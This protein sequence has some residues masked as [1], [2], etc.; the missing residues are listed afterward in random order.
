MLCQFNGY[1]R[2]LAKWN[3]YFYIGQSK[4]RRLSTFRENFTNMSMDTGVHI[5]NSVIKTSRF[6]N[7]PAEQVFDILLLPKTKEDS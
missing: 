3:E 5:W 7:I 2:G 6:I 4:A 1:T